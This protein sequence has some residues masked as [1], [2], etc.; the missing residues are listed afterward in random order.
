MAKYKSTAAY[1][2]ADTLNKQIKAV[3]EA[4]GGDSEVYQLYVNRITAELPAGAVHMG[5]GGYI[6]LSK[7]KASG[8]SAR[9]INKA[10]YG[11]P[12]VKRAKGTYKRQ[13]AEERLAEGGNLYPTESEIKKEA[14][15]VTEEEV[16]QYIDDKSFVKSYEDSKHKLKYDASVADL[17]KTAGAK[18]YELLAAILREGEL[19]SNAEAQNEADNANRVEN[20]YETGK[21]NTRGKG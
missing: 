12:D 8:A 9:Q 6:Q 5:K 21:A 1:R 7:G 10:K 19:R 20:S 17:M 18:S 11:L 3:Y 4:F 15:T 14:K 13:I 2:A 16:K